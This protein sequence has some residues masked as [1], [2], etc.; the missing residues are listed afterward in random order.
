MSE[1]VYG[2]REDPGCLLAHICLLPCLCPVG[3]IF[4][5]LCLSSLWSLVFVYYYGLSVLASL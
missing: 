1:D 2:L 4:L 5:V 3:F